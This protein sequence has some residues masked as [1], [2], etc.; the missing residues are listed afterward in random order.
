M[1]FA[2]VGC[3]GSNILFSNV[4]PVSHATL[5]DALKE[6]KLF[7]SCPF[8]VKERELQVVKDH[9]AT[10]CLSGLL[11][12]RSISGLANC[13]SSAMALET[14]N[15]WLDCG[16]NLLL[17]DRP[18]FDTLTNISVAETTELWAK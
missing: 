2:V 13:D 15:Q 3:L 14:D 9:I 4:D 16:A 12:L 5:H 7:L 6:E 1:L 10:H 18:N 11:W 17:V 8:L